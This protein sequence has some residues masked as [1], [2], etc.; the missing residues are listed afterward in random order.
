MCGIAGLFNYKFPGDTLDAR[1][2]AV[3]QRIL[4]SESLVYMEPRGKD[5]TGIAL[6]WDDKQT[7][8]VKQPVPVT[9]WARDDGQYDEDFTNPDDDLANFGWLMKTWMRGLP[10]TKITQALGHVRKRTVGSE[11]NMHNNHPIIIR[12]EDVDQGE[13]GDGKDLLVGIHNGGIS[14]ADELFKKHKYKRIGQVDSEVIFQHMYRYKD[15]ITVENLSDTFRELKGVFATMAYNP[16]KPNIV[17]CMK[18]VRPLDGAYIPELGTL[19]LISERRFLNQ[20]LIDYDRWRVREAGNMFAIKDENQEDQILGTV[21]DLFPSLSCKWQN[22]ISTGVFVLDLTQEVDD[23]TVVRDLVKVQ[24][25]TKAATS[26]KT[27]T[28]NTTDNRSVS[29]DD[30]KKPEKDEKKDIECRHKDADTVVS[31]LSVYDE[32]PEQASSDAESQEDIDNDEESKEI[33]LDDEDNCPYPWEDRHAMALEALY[34]DDAAK[35]HRLLITQLNDLNMKDILGKF[36]IEVTDEDKAKAE[37]A[38]YYDAIFPEGFCV[39]VEHGYNI[40]TDELSAA[41]QDNDDLEEELS[42]R[43]EELE[44]AVE[45]KEK[46]MCRMAEKIQEIEKDKQKVQKSLV[47]KGPVYRYL[48]RQHGVM[49]DSG[50]V[51][52]PKFKILLEASHQDQVRVTQQQANKIQKA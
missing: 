21:G 47:L 28:T 36:L 20:A 26:N 5:S 22:S 44:A 13:I 19:L 17:G 38:S 48:L 14:N 24:T 11:Y 49:D 29:S 27:N 15:D 32:E 42:T 33:N 1:I 46:A 35:N 9:D 34:D 41:D 3:I 52:K 12:P 30:K 16:Q 7:A 4:L 23:K 37:F 45:A 39:G 51:D 40:A 25:V 50:K 43:I 2:K 8:I 6:V 18:E 10:N 31:D